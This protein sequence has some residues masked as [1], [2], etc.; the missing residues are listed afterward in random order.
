M[1]LSKVKIFHDGSHFVAK[2]SVPKKK[3]F[4][5]GVSEDNSEFEQFKIFYAEAIEKSVFKNNIP[6]FIQGRF[7]ECCDDIFDVPDIDVITAYYK[8]Y[9]TMIHKRTQ[10]AQR[11]AYLNDWNYFVTFTY[12]SDKMSQEEFERQIR[13]KLSDLSSHSN[14]YSMIRWEE[15]EVGER[16]HL[17]AFI[18]VPEGKMCGEL[19]RDRHYSTKRHRWEFFWNNTYF[20]ERF[21][22]SDWKDLSFYKNIKPLVNYLLK[23]MAKDDG[24]IIYSRGIPDIIEAEIDIDEHILAT[25]ESHNRILGVV[26][27]F[28]FGTPQEK[29]A[30]LRSCFDLDTYVRAEAV[31]I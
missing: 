31:P 19:Y 15:G 21:G 28:I 29:A 16:K 17:H 10:R 12:D 5:R 23:Y 1:S 26:D 20:N 7:I 30:A 18:Y 22:V 3:Y 14:W 24:K 6:D 2:L 13:T 25:Y 27:R 9:V 11:K 4:K 8:R